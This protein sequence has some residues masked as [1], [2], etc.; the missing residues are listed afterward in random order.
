MMRAMR[1][2]LT[3]TILTGAA[4][5][6]ACD[7]TD[8]GSVKVNLKPD[9]GGTIT[10]ACLSVPAAGPAEGAASGVTWEA[11][12]G[13]V[14]SSG[15]FA[16]LAGVKIGDLSFATI[17]EG[18]ATVTVV[19]LPRGASAKWPAVLSVSAD[20]RDQAAKIMDPDAAS[21]KRESK[22]G[23]TAK[24]EITWSGKKVV[25]HGVDARVRGLSSDGL[26]DTATLIVP[27]DWAR[28]EG[29]PIEWRVTWE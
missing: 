1:T 7:E 5:M 8:A 4:W 18:N 10:A 19:T 16:S 24:V 14:V 27:I 25:S 22:F 23:Q 9:G 29:S 28:G 21:Q 12:G 17:N 6:A 3:A 15:S 13:V 2:A 20:K 11:R 26:K